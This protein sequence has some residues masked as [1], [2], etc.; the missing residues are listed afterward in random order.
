MTNL[1]LNTPFFQGDD[2]AQIRAATA[3]QK[4]KDV[5]AKLHDGR[6]LSGDEYSEG[7]I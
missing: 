1:G 5:I 3:S 7:I 2:V 6:E 4:I